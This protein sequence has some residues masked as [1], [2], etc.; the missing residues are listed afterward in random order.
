MPTTATRFRAFL[1]A[2][3]A[4]LAGC[5][6]PHGGSGDLAVRSLRDDAVMLPGRFVEA[7]YWQSPESETSFL[8]SDVPLSRLAESRPAEAQVLHIELLWLPKAG[9]TPMDSSATNVSIRHIIISRDEI[10]VYGG[11]GFAMPGGSPGDDRLSLSIE[12]A[13]LALLD[14]TPGFV[15]LLSPG[16]LTGSVKAVRDPARARQ[17]HLLVSQYVTN[18]LG[19]TRFIFEH[20]R[21]QP[22]A[23][24]RVADAGAAD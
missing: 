7:V 6:G 8:L 10:G 16:R 21:Q 9:A 13:S 23:H 18:A 14:A 2:G 11:A 24:G 12:D 15:D 5:A 3:A 4:V 1:L 22:E 19:R 20:Q 17:L